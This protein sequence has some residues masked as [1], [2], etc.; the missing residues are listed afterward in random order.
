MVVVVVVQ[1]NR[2]DIGKRGTMMTHPVINIQ[3]YNSTINVN[4]A[5]HTNILL[6][7]IIVYRILS[8]LT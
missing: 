3:L 7:V 8:I 2:N 6:K 1:K 4:I 5:K